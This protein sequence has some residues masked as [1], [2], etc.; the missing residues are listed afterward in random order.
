M[1]DPL[2]D[3][4]ATLRMRGTLYF[5][6]DYRAPWGVSVPELYGKPPATLPP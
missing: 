1:L 4:L 6:T 3:V 5:R 2:T